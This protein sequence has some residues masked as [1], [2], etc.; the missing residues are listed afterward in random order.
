ML[1]VIGGTG[2]VGRPLVTMLRAAGAPVR[3]LVRDPA[4]A[5]DLRGLGVE[6]AAGDLAE[7]RTVAAAMAGVERVFLATPPDV[8]QRELQVHAID[9]ARRAGV[10]HLVKLSVAG[11]DEGSRNALLSWHG[12]TDDHLQAS[13]MRWTV[14]RPHS[15][16]VNTLAF[17]P[18]V[19]AEGRFHASDTGRVPFV[20]P[21]D[22]AAV[23]AG[24][25]TAEGH[26]GQAY[27]VTGP[28]L[29]SYADVASTLGRVL[30]RDVQWVPLPVDAARAGMRAAGMPP[31]LVD[32][33]LDFNERFARGAAPALTDVVRRVGGAEPT[34]YEQFARETAALFQPTPGAAAR[35]GMA[36]PR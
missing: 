22:V 12:E 8:R 17:A 10:R 3:A 25:L 6:L 11:A 31:W 24:A 36:E 5:A 34:T 14:L 4:R 19:A 7:P 33:L 28:E 2:H 23:G 18:G 20:H 27:E 29:L 35:R 30:G 15:F 9:A 1:L 16:M 21:R 13:G 32:S 26:A